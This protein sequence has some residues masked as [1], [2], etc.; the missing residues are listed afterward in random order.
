M[1]ARHQLAKVAKTFIQIVERLDNM[2]ADEISG[3]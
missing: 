1:V 2:S 3:Q